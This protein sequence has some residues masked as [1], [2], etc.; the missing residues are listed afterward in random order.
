MRTHIIWDWNGTLFHDMEAVL[1]ASNAAFATIGVAPMTL[2]QYRDSYEVPVPRFYERLLGRAP[3]QAEWD[4]LDGVFHDR[5]T[6]LRDR[7]G[8]TD[9]VPALLREWQAA[10][11]SQ[12]LLSMYEHEQL[13][14][15]VDGFGITPHFVRVDGRVGDAGGRKAGFLVRH[16]AALAP[17]VEPERTVLIGDA[18]DDALAALESGAHAVLYT[19][20]SHSRA[21]LEQ[22][23][24]PVVDT[25]AEAVEL[26]ARITV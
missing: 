24:V 21:K 13:V 20:G 8:L 19:G 22:V 11:N 26:A 7:C 1:E 12:S 4:H 14:P 23:G 2:Q 16:L 25:L 18:A 17:E 3:S 5:Y 10:G 6:E 9:G 15:V